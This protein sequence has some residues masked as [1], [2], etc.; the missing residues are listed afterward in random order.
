[1]IYPLVKIE[2]DDAHGNGRDSWELISDREHELE[3]AAFCATVGH[4]IKESKGGKTIALTVSNE[5]E[6]QMNGWIFIP[7]RYIKKI[8]M[9]QEVQ[10]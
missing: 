3:E 7:N 9:L 8:T 1:M 6:T 4:L 10:Q 2:W 5:A